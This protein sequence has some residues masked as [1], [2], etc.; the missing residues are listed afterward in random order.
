MHILV[1]SRTIAYNGYITQATNCSCLIK[2]PCFFYT[3]IQCEL[4]L[5]VKY[6][7][8]KTIGHCYIY[9]PCNS[10]DLDYPPLC[11]H[12]RC[13]LYLCDVSLESSVKENL[14]LQEIWTDGRTDRL[15]H[16]YL[17]K[18]CLLGYKK[19]TP[20]IPIL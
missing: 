10:L 14:H 9:I 8:Y 19:T 6:H 17:P 13:I 7:K 12:S 18:L 4:K 16:I 1:N 2:L 11:T 15:I 3:F 5:W 20:N